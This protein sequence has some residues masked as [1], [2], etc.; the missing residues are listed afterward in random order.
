M[1]NSLVVTTTARATEFGS[2]LLTGPGTGGGRAAVTGLW[3]ASAVAAV[4]SDVA[5]VA[6][7]RIVLPGPA[8]ASTDGGPVVLQ[9]A[10]PTMRMAAVAALTAFTGGPGSRR[11]ARRCRTGG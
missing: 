1:S 10:R 11:V 9:A 5:A 7:A 8:A 6:W 3:S 2:A 4:G